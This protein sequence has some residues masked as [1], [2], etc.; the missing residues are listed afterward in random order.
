MDLKPHIA[1]V[2]DFP[3]A[4]ILFRD[5]MPLLRSHFEPAVAAM[6]S[7]L[8]P[9][10]WQQVDT[11]AGIESR[12]FILGAALALRRGKGFVAIRKQG[13]LPPPVLSLS[14]QL[15]YGPATLEMQPG[16]GRVAIIDDVMA[17]GGTMTAAA[18]L[19]T[20]SGFSVCAL[21]ALIDL[22]LVPPLQWNGLALRASLTYD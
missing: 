12:G 5:I 10:E 11:I 14:Y 13:K 16:S 1:A 7:L 4:G 15:E 18:Q 20:R 8:S 9:D 22:Q 2:P 21:L 6:E 19:C 3:K 17:T